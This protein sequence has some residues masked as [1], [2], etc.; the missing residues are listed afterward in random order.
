MRMVEL[1]ILVREMTSG[2]SSPA[3]SRRS[4]LARA[5]DRAELPLEEIGR[6]IEQGR[7]SFAF[8]EAPPFRRW[9]QRTDR[10]YREV[11]REAG[12]S[13]DFSGPFSGRSANCPWRGPPRSGAH[14][15]SA[16]NPCPRSATLRPQQSSWNAPPFEPHPHPLLGLRLHRLK[17][18]AT[19]QPPD[20]PAEER[21]EDSSPAEMT[22]RSRVVNRVWYPSV[23]PSRREA[24][25]EPEHHRDIEQVLTRWQRE[26]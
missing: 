13:F 17:L 6:A 7:V 9:A 25:L 8:L 20:I 26:R 10:T 3:T 23:H 22:V 16:S 19:H 14:H 4:A 15:D 24:E 12:V 18:Q 2:L 5:C 21:A 11:C 1:G